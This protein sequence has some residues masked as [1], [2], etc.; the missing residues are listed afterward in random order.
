MRTKMMLGLICGL[1]LL[2]GVSTVSYANETQADKYWVYFG[3]YTAKGGSK[4]IYRSEFDPK[5]GKLS[6]PEV[7]AE[8]TNP[9]FL[10]FSPNGKFLYSVG[11]VSN[12]GGK[13][14]GGVHAFGVDAS[15]GK[16]SKL[17]EQTSGGPGPCHV[18]TDAAGKNV[19]VAN[20]GGGSSSI[21]PVK[22]DGSL[23]EASAFF[24]HEGS[25]VNKGRQSAP[26]A[27]CGFFDETGKFAFVADLG[28]DQVLI[29][30]VDPETGKAEPNNPPFI[31]LPDGSGPRHLHIAPGNNLMFVNGEL[32]STVSVVK[33]Q[34]ENGRFAVTQTLSTLPEPT[35][36]NSTA[37]VRIHP[38]GKFVYV[39]NR[40]HNSIAAFSWDGDKLTPIGHITSENVKIPRNFNI[41]PSGKWM[42]VASQDGDNIAVFAIDEKTGLAKPTGDKVDVP[43]P[44]CVKFLAQPK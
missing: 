42:L 1:A 30:K 37:E 38:S 6:E 40:G 36:G 4:G 14:E 23:G 5:T 25:S 24:Q 13:K 11:E 33:M 27:H 20:Y 15:T 12:T 7:A 18:S 41:D 26:H 17:N 19:V 21:F 8:L 10:Y 44:V 9:T 43:R 28:L 3:T 39:S 34:P 22:P 35:P 31:K 32:D 29:Y 2:S 16:L